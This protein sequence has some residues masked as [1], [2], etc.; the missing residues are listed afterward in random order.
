M[1]IGSGIKGIFQFL[2]NLDFLLWLSSFQ[3]QLSFF[4]VQGGEIQG[5]LNVLKDEIK[6]IKNVTLTFKL[7][8]MILLGS[9]Y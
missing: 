5:Q 2:D 8:F 6:Y 3:S 4:L 1:R 9:L 7:A